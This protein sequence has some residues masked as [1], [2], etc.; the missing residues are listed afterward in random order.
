MISMIGKRLAISAL[1]SNSGFHMPSLDIFECDENHSMDSNHFT[2]WIDR[3]SS[4]IRKELGKIT[5][6]V[7]LLQCIHSFLGKDARV[8]LIL[9][10]ATW[11]NRLTEET[12]PPKR[13]WKK[14]V[15]INWLDRH[16]LPFSENM[17]KAEL[18]EVALDNLPPKRYIVDEVAAKHNVQILR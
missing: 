13:S 4:I 9:D 14:Q 16:D 5:Q 2:A 12:T 8:S 1:L 15:I 17:T 3:T 6:S 7:Y 18:L 11:H 10:N